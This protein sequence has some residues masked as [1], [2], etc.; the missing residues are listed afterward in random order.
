M[1]TV[2]NEKLA[3]SYIK[4]LEDKLLKKIKPLNKKVTTEDIVEFIF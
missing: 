3:R 2:M 1:T 4:S